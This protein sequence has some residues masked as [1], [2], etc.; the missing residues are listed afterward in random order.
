MFIGIKAIY[1]DGTLSIQVWNTTTGEA[2]GEFEK[3]SPNIPKPC[4]ILNYD[5]ERDLFNFLMKK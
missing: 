3:G 5:K 2:V 4:I 1:P